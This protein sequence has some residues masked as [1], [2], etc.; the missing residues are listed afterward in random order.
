[1]DKNIALQTLGYQSEFS[2]TEQGLIIDTTNNR[3]VLLNKRNGL[4]LTL[5]NGQRV[6]RSIRTLYRQAFGKEYSIDNIQDLQGEVW[7]PIDKFSRYLVSNCGR[8]KSYARIEAVLL[9]PR[10]TEN[11]Y[12]RVDLWLDK[13]KSYLVHQLVARAFVAN[14][15]PIANDTVD[16]IDRD[17]RNNYA[18]NLRWMTR[19]DNVRAY[20]LSLKEERAKCAKAICEPKESMC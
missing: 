9:K 12:L 14:D 17:K 11:G 5:E 7:K 1:M 6:Q 20:Q 4:S 10:I 15:N 3:T 13:R 2:I 8:V 18:N 16:H 19:G